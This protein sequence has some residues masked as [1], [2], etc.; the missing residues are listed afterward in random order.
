MESCQKGWVW[1]WGI[2]TLGPL[3]GARS[4]I[5]SFRLKENKEKREEYKKGTRD[6]KHCKSPRTSCNENGFGQIHAFLR[7]MLM[8]RALPQTKSA[9]SKEEKRGRVRKCAEVRGSARKCAAKCAQVRG[10]VRKCAPGVCARAQVRGSAR[11]CAEVC[12]VPVCGNP[13][14][15]K[16]RFSTHSA[17]LVFFF[18]RN[19]HFSEI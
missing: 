2:W 14:V 9:T 4:F 17:T 11:K 12:A 3:W 19:T 15:R 6:A 16:N 18:K 10:S 8:H 7:R 13:V 5:F 1:A